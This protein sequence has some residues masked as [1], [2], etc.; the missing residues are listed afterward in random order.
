MDKK[1][2]ELR[3]QQFDGFKANYEYYDL[4]PSKE[5]IQAFESY[6]SGQIDAEQLQRIFHNLNGSTTEFRQIP[7]DQFC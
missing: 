1:E 2:R 5:K 3:Q 4:T 7:M 6:V